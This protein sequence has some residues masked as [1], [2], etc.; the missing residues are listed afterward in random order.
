[1]GNI[2]L[3]ISQVFADEDI[4]CDIPSVPGSMFGDYNWFL[5]AIRLSRLTSIAYATLF[6]TR[7]EVGRGLPMLYQTRTAWARRMAL[8]GTCDISAE[9]VNPT[10]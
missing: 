7:F 1:M 8:I 10:K 3:I 9:G 5:S 2:L 6:S 4:G